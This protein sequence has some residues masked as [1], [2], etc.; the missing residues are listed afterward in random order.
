[1]ID[2]VRL[3]DI[4]PY[5]IRLDVAVETEQRIEEFFI[6]TNP[7]RV[8]MKNLES[9]PQV[10]FEPKPGGTFNRQAHTAE[11]TASDVPR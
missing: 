6:V 10:F 4:P 3:N 5:A 9:V 8:R 7:S 1:M 2:E 11:A